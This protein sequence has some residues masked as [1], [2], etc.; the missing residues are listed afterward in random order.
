MGKIIFGIFLNGFFWD[1][2]KGWGADFLKF[3]L[4]KVLAQ[5]DD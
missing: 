4:N 3:N 2:G 1:E 5:S